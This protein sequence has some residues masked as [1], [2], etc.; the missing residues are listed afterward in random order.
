MQIKRVIV[1]GLA[2][3]VFSLMFSNGADAQYRDRTRGAQAAQE[4]T[5]RKFDRGGSS[6]R[7]ASDDRRVGRDKQ[8][9]RHRVQSRDTRPRAKRDGDRSRKVGTQRRTYDRRAE[10]RWHRDR[11]SAQRRIYIPRRWNHNDRPHRRNLWRRRYNRVWWCGAECRIA[12]LFGFT[13][14]AINTVVAH[15]SGYSF[16]IWEALEYNAT[17]ETSLWESSWGYVEFTPTKT[18][19]RRFGRSIRNCR[20]FLRV[21]VRNEGLE[22]RYRGTACRNPHGAW[23]IVS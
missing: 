4:D 19:R 7:A 10:R 14:W 18:F 23:W 12:L 15:D 21:V 11:P 17:G 2:A 6:R 22:R 16:P 20:D 9:P 3:L 1:C 8:A 5:E 13:V